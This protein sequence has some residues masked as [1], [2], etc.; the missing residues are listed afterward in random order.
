MAASYKGR[1]E[2]FRLLTG[3]GQYTSDWNRPNQLYGHF[4]RSDR[5]HAEIASLDVTAA[6]AAPG[7]VAVLTGADTVKAGCK[8]AQPLAKYPGKGGMKIKEPMRHPLANGRVRFV[9]EEVAFVVAESVAAAQDAAELI[10]I[11]YRDL[12][13]VVD[14]EA[15]LKPGAPLLH[16]DA[17]GNMCFEYEYGDAAKTAEAFAGAAHVTKLP[18]GIRC[19][20]GPLRRLHLHPGPVADPAFAGRRGEPPGGQDPRLRSR[21]GRRVRRAQRGLS[22]IRGRDA[23]READR[24]AG[25]MDIDAVGN[26]AERPPRP[27]R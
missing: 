4:L 19:R 17:P 23:G 13:V 24:T 10:E 9:G 20:N 12:P 22:G 6:R 25:E 16:D 27:R 2:D 3:A 15:A 18:G 8:S 5:A 26:A 1:R 7:V 14:A 21:R 11:D